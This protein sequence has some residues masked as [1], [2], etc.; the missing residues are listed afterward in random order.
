MA[1]LLNPGLKEK[2]ENIFEGIEKGRTKALYN[3]FDDTWTSLELLKDKILVYFQKE[4]EIN[5][6]KIGSMLISHKTL[7]PDFSE[8]FICTSE[9][10]VIVSTYKEFENRK[11]K[12]EYITSFQKNEKVMYGPYIDMDTL[13]IGECQSKFF[14]EVTLMFIE[15]MIVEGA[16]YYICGRIPNDVMSDILQDEDS[17]IYKESGDNYLFMVNTKRDI[18]P[19]MAISR[20]RFEDNAFT[21]GDNL[22]D[23]IKTNGYGVV[24]IKKH[25]EFEVL[26]NNPKSKQLH[27]GVLNTIKNGSNL[28]AWP[29]Y[30]E[31][32]HIPV[33]GKGILIHPPHS[34]ETWGLLCEGD[35]TKRVERRA[36]DET[37][38]LGR[39]FNKFINS[40]LQI[41]RRILRATLITNDS[42]DNLKK[43]TKDLTGNI[44]DVDHMVNGNIQLISTYAEELEGLQARFSEMS[45]SI[46]GMVE[47]IASAKT[48]MDEINQKAISSQSEAQKSSSIMS[49]IVEDI[50]STHDGINSLENQSNKVQEVISVI[51]SISNQTKLLALNASI[52]AARAG[53]H[54]KGFSVVAEEISKLANLTSESTKEITDIINTMGSEVNNNKERIVLIDDKIKEG[55]NQVIHSISS[56]KEI[57]EE[58]GNITGSIEEI[59]EGVKSTSKEIETIKTFVDHSIG[60]FK[61]SSE[62]SKIESERI[63]QKL[64][65]EV[66]H[67]REIGDALNYTSTHLH[68]IVTEFKI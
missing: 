36:N 48:Q 22:K 63:M 47:E 65:F 44:G 57:Q 41:V 68:D 64:A 66:E 28:E 56:F 6:N 24:Q 18:E 54:G 20:S 31:Y 9:G 32:R 34:A 35:L 3:W 16:R 13:K 30:P 60:D 14:D 42:V 15:P 25:T 46:N 38:E 52:E 37:G 19:G 2:T 26:F 62:E 8:I 4:E 1:Y 11:I 17:H 39:W 67:M 23:G 50:S 40:Q 49:E 59:T 61:M 43:V 10:K 55:N 29:G 7:F 45:D 58:I 53:E 21:L 51:D 12:E 33:G 27:E 5:R